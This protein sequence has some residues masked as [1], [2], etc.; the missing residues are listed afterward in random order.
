MEGVSRDGGR[1]AVTEK[2]LVF[3]RIRTCTCTCTH[4]QVV[5]IHVQDVAVR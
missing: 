2:I 1:I 5:Y 4:V 3:F